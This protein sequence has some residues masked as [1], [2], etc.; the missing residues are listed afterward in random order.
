MTT[1]NLSM[2]PYT[3]Q[4]LESQCECRTPA[5]KAKSWRL[6]TERRH[7]VVVTLVRHI[8][9]LHW[10]LR[11]LITDDGEP[12]MAILLRTFWL[13]TASASRNKTA[14]FCLFLLK[15]CSHLW[16][17]A[18]NTVLLHYFRSLANACPYLIPILFRSIFN[19]I[20]TSFMAF[21]FSL[22]ITFWQSLCVSTFL[23]Y[24]LLQ[25]PYH[26]NLSDCIN[27]TMSYLNSTPCSSLFC[28]YSSALCLSHK[29]FL[30]CHILRRNCPL[31]QVI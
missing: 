18:S 19:F 21:R 1:H 10:A 23:H 20:S 3:C 13:T 28:S 9:P 26:I 15:L 11:P 29:T 22:F 6:R 8:E 5:E 25:Y 2:S 12:N 7:A 14:L 30:F 16:T 4:F 17:L 24:S 31:E 27:F